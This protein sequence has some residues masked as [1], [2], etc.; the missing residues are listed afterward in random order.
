MSTSLPPINH[1]LNVLLAICQQ[2]FFNMFPFFHLALEIFHR[3]EGK[4]GH[5][6]SVG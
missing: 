1:H 5:Y 3:G 4:W 2:V 6:K